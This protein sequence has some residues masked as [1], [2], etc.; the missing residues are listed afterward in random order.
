MAGVDV[1]TGVSDLD[2]DRVPD[3]GGGVRVLID[4]TEIARLISEGYE[5]RLQQAVPVRPLDPS[6]IA[7][8]DD[9]DSWFASG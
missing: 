3:P 5:V 1:S 8:D 7:R 2:L 9:V 4:Q 6:L